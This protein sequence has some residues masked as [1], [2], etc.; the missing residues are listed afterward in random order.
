M[1]GKLEGK[2]VAFLATDGVEQVELPSRGRP[3]SRRAAGPS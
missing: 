1:S 2:R 3:S